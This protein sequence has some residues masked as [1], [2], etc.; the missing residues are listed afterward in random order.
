MNELW[1]VEG[2]KADCLMGDLG[3][4]MGWGLEN[5]VGVKDESHY[6]FFR[7][8]QVDVGYLAFFCRMER[9]IL[10]LSDERKKITCSK[11]F[12]RIVIF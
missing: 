10:S 11:I 4:R 5:E 2:L 3:L 6:F 7:S 9:K 1:L 8:F 12:K